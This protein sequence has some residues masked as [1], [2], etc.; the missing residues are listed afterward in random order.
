MTITH[1]LIIEAPVQDV[2]ALTVDVESWPSMTPTITSVERLDTGPLRV[3]STARI[4]Q[5]GQSARV[6]TVT[7]LKPNEVFVWETK[8]FG[9]RM[10]GG[11]RLEQVGEGCRNVLSIGMS[12]ALSGLVEAMLKSQLRKT[13]ATENEGFRRAALAAHH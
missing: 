6:W 7:A 8:A 10:V 5:P 2:W 13:I 11:H 3:G 12:G 1:E 4:R 9:M